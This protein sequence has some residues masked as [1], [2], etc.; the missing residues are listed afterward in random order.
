[1]EGN[2]LDGYVPGKDGTNLKSG[3]TIGIGFDIG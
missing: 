1:M 3:V 2:K